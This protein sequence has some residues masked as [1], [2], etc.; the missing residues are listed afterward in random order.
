MSKGTSTVLDSSMAFLEPFE[1]GSIVLSAF[2]SSSVHNATT[3]GLRN[4]KSEFARHQTELKMK[5]P[6]LMIIRE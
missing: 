5:D 1:L 6:Y 2:L 3:H 4:R